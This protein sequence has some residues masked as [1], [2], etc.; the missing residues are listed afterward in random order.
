[1]VTR[2][3]LIKAGMSSIFVEAKYFSSTEH[4][5]VQVR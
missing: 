4:A 1:M 3:D 5:P 2:Q